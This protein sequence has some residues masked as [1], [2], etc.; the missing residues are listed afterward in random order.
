MPAY[1]PILATLGYV[2]SPDGGSVLMIHRNA[3]PDDLHYG[4]YNGLGGKLDPYEDAVSG[5]KREIHEEAGITVEELVLRGT[6]N[7]PGFG[8]NEEDWFAFIFRIDR[9]SGTPYSSNHEGSLEWVPVAQLPTLN[10]WESDRLW[11][12]MVFDETPRTF[13]GIAPYK[14]GELVS[15]SYVLI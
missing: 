1:T 4:K 12:D 13:H 9:W 10:L 14:N 2:M 5:M 6:V 15:W 3:R 7:W 11:L 8:K